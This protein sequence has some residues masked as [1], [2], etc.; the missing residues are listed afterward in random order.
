[1]DAPGHKSFVPSMIEGASQADYAILIISARRGEFETGEI[2]F[3]IFKFPIRPYNQLRNWSNILR[4]ALKKQFSNQ[5]RNWCNILR[6]ASKRVLTSY[7]QKHLFDKSSKSL[8]KSKEARLSTSLE[9]EVIYYVRLKTKS[10][11]TLR[12]ESYIHPPSPLNERWNLSVLRSL[13]G[14]RSFRKAFFS[15]MAKNGF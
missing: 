2:F 12:K 11:N 14:T 15:P 10:F 8:K 4:H 6:Q 1:M 13:R 9:T 3:I 7:Y 5:L